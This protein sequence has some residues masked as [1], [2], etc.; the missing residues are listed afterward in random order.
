MRDIGGDDP[1]NIVMIN[2]GKTEAVAELRKIVGDLDI[3][4]ITEPAYGHMYGEAEAVYFVEDIADLTAMR[5][6]ALELHRKRPIDFII[7]PSERSM[8]AGGFLRSYLGLDGQGAEVANAFSN[9]AQMKKL[10]GDAGI[11]VAPFRAVAGIH[12]LSFAADE[13]G[14]P[15]VVKPAFGTGSMNTYR[16]DSAEDLAT[17]LGGPAAEAILAAHSLVLVEKYI[18]MQGEY[19]CDAVVIDR[20]VRASVVSRYFDP[21]LGRTGMTAGAFTLDE[22]DRDVVDIREL[23]RRTVS[24]LGLK[25]GV[26]HMELFKVAEGFLVGEIACRPGGV[27]VPANALAATGL[28]LWQAFYRDALGMDMSPVVERLHRPDGVKFWTELPASPGRITAMTTRE[29][30]LSLP[31][32]TDVKLMATPGD[33]IS[34]RMHSS[35]T[36]GLIFLELP[37]SRRDEVD[38]HLR[39]IEETFHLEVASS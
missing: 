21:L 27:G 12:Q 13:V 35:S 37:S 31:D 34:S 39:L 5:D 9:K 38:A 33:T 3:S 8:L 2:S 14:F 10:L 25:G 20:E 7:S 36:T 16:V 22:G 24:A 28:D 19:T 23:H 11:P 17:L 15:V 30:L 6:L 18:P 32:V 29:Q 4:V 1:P 26:T